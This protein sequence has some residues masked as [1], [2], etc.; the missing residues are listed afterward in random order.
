MGIYFTGADAEIVLKLQKKSSERVAAKW[1]RFTTRRPVYL[2]FCI[3][4]SVQ[5]CMLCT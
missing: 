1:N 4:S 2:T 3:S 5:D